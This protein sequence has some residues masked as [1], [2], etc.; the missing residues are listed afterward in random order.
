MNDCF[1][2]LWRETIFDIDGVKMNHHHF[3]VL[4]IIISLSYEDVKL[5]THQFV[6]TMMR[7]ILL[8][9]RESLYCTNAIK[10]TYIVDFGGKK[11]GK[12]YPFLQIIRK[13]AI[14]TSYLVTWFHKLRLKQKIVKGILHK[15]H[16]YIHISFE[17]IFQQKVMIQ[18]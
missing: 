17:W 5:I 18:W 11:I 13:Y 10:E 15:I 12:T 9:R 14:L 7:M 1:A 16:C 6:Q 8:Q 3:L 2:F 4:M